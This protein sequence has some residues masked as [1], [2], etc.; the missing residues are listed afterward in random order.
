MA[1]YYAPPI[2]P[3][4]RR[5]SRPKP[6]RRA[7][8]PTYAAYPTPR[9][10]PAPSRRAV[11]QARVQARQYPS[12]ARQLKT[13]AHRQRRAAVKRVQRQQLRAARVRA[14]GYRRV[15]RKERIAGP[16]TPPEY[17]RIRS[18]Q[19]LVSTAE[20]RSKARGGLG[21]QPGPGTITDLSDRLRFAQLSPAQQRTE[22]LRRRSVY[23]AKRASALS[24]S[25]RPV[26]KAGEQ[27]AAKVKGPAVFALEQASRPLYATAGGTKAA[28]KG[29]NVARAVARGATLKDHTTFSDVLAASG[30]RPKSGL[31][32]FARGAVGFGLDVAADP[33]TYVTF[34]VSS[35]ARG[36]ARTAATRAAA[37]ATRAKA[38]EE[39]AKVARRIARGELTDKAEIKAAKKQA[40]RTARQHGEAVGR[41][42]YRRTLAQAAEHEHRG[43]VT[44]RVAGGRRVR[45]AIEATR[46]PRGGRVRGR[47]A[48]APVAPVVRTTRAA[49]AGARALARPVTRTKLAQRTAQR[50]R[51]RASETFAPIRPP[52]VTSKQWAQ[53][54][55]VQRESRAS[56][57]THVRRVTARANA[58]LG[59]LG[60]GEARAV[61][62]AVE[63][64]NI[65]SL[66]GTARR[67]SISRG[68]ALRAPG[69]KA[70]ATRGDPDRL[71]KVARQI[72]SDIR[73]LNRV[74]RRSGLI[75]G[76]VGRRSRTREEVELMAQAGTTARSVR[77][78]VRELA[79]ARREAPLRRIPT[80][81]EAAV[82]TLSRAYRSISD[83]QT[84]ARLTN[85]RA[86]RFG[87]RY[88][89]SADVVL[90]GQK[91]G[92]IS[93]FYDPATGALIKESTRVEPKFQRRGIALRL[94]QAEEKALARS[95]ARRVETV[96]ITESGKALTRRLGGFKPVGPGAPGRQFKEIRG[97]NARERAAARQRVKNLRKRLVGGTAAVER[98]A[99]ARTALRASRAE[100]G[101]REA[102]AY[103]PRVAKTELERGGE[104]TELVEQGARRPSGVVGGRA[105]KAKAGK[106]RQ[107]R[108]SRAVL[109]EG[110][111][112]QRAIAGALSED[113]RG[114]LAAYGTQVGRGSAARELNAQIARTLGR[115]LPRN[116]SREGLAQIERDGGQV[117]KLRRNELVPLTGKDNWPQ[118]KRVSQGRAPKGSP[119]QYVVVPRRAEQLA[120]EKGELALSKGVIAGYDIA[121][122]GFKGVALATP[123]YLVRNLLGD[124]FNATVHENPFRLARNMA[125]G[126]KALNELGRY[127]KAMR[128]FEKRIP[129]SKRTVKLTDQQAVAVRNALATDPRQ[130]TGAAK[131]EIPA[132]QVALLAEKMG[133]IRQ[134][135]FLELMEEAG[136]VPKPR[137]THAWQDASKRVEDS[138]RIATFLG[139]LQRGLSPRAAAG[140]ASKI[141]FDYGDLTTIEKSV[142]R[143]VMPFYTFTARNIPLQAKGIVT[144]PGL[145]AAVQ[146]AREEGR[147]QAGLPSGY[148]E[149]LDP[150][151]A[152]QLGVPIKFGNKTLTLSVGS[153]F[154]DLNDITAATGALARGAPTRASEIAG[155]RM[156]ELASPILK[157]PAELL[158]NYSFFY[159]DQIE[160]GEPL[161][162]APAEI[163][164]LGKRNPAIAKRLG[165]VPDYV[166]SDTGKPT[167]GWGRR[168]DYAYR[169]LQFG[170]IS[171][172][173]ELAGGGAKGLNARN[174]TK[175]Q[176]VATDLG[177]R[178]PTYSPERNRTNALYDEADTLEK[179]M[180]RL[181]RRANPRNGER[182]SAD[183]PTPEYNRLR[184]RAST[185]EREL[186]KRLRKSNVYVRGRRVAPTAPSSGRLPVAP[187][188]STGGQQRLPVAK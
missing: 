164:A 61:I 184:A 23:Q 9:P 75:G 102:Q 115:P 134:G 186:D 170:P 119:A 24:A 131:R 18:L 41:R 52:G 70:R 5:R 66:K 104:L 154:V 68:Q 100:R 7:Y 185:V 124:A 114:T 88:S 14:R 126:Q 121:S 42:Q 188:I 163:V 128:R 12:Q 139:G 110:S 182:I 152:R 13:Q 171:S 60:E 156:A 143:R 147:K 28:I 33:L 172:I 10:A 160:K 43:G 151:E 32:K 162:R 91:I 39:S 144:K 78:A 67:A 142:F 53:I 146:A 150:Y 85:V 95:G 15:E 177:L 3:A 130:L 109:R 34:G 4:P 92:R 71:F 36:A 57:E 97:P 157:L 58:L 148:E 8:S 54:K 38:A 1:T 48:R 111:K 125:R 129:E 59:R 81:P 167:W 113:V 108:E 77:P 2:L 178:A 62:D 29:Q 174:M 72:R 74:G 187:R 149:T 76:Q 44:V 96:P 50:A 136:K 49:G 89:M 141:H 37:A 180:T 55:A 175:L 140:R 82:E 105:P 45:R 19:R 123:G 46:R 87:D 101:G 161:T 6:K 99:G 155:R 51:L 135:R 27:V 112:K 98:A 159:R 35:V 73:Y 137:G 20:S 153:P 16:P 90:E 145:Y 40:G 176:R 21:A 17:L 122:R 47:G 31:G 86:G 158:S 30:W 93:R 118:I 183:N 84:G 120:R 69:R 26:T 169:N 181:R 106:R 133:V 64:G 94:S 165:L 80:D 117:F 103:Y 83:R 22:G 56:G 107:Y 11:R 132:T 127:E 138:T 168:A 116:L 63:S 79:Q 65:A 179:Q 166:P 173:I 25:L